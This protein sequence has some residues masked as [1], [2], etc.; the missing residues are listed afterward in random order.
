MFRVH[1]YVRHL[2]LSWKPFC[3]CFDSKKLRR[4]GRLACRR[5]RQRASPRRRSS[6]PRWS[7]CRSIFASICGLKT[8][9]C[10][11]ACCCFGLLQQS[12]SQAE[13]CAFPPARV[14][15]QYVR[16]RGGSDGPAK[17]LG[18]RTKNSRTARS[19]MFREER[20]Q[21][22]V[23]FDQLEELRTSCTGLRY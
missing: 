12:Q 17:M 7:E 3:F 8:T 2:D 19:R 15:H 4:R 23:S 18:P 10:L 9:S 22:H 1:W 20:G 13:V 5:G 21:Q 11:S 6:W 16:V 14:D